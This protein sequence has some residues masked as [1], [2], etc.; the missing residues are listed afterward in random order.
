MH[1]NS[2]SYTDLNAM[3]QLKVGSKADSAENLQQVA[4]QFE[5]L[6]LNVMV[7]S[8]RDANQAFAEGNPLN[9]PQTRFYQD[10]YDS[11]LSVHLAEKQGMGLADVM[12]RQLSP[13][14]AAPAAPVSN[15]ATD[16]HAERPDHSA[17]LARRR[18]GVRAGWGEVTLGQVTAAAD[19]P[20]RTT[21]PASPAALAEPSSNWL[22][23][24]A[25]HAAA[26]SPAVAAATNAKTRFDS[27]A[28]FTRAM[29][30]M[31]EK[32]AARLG[33]DPHYLVAQAALETG[34]GKSI[35][36]NG[37]GTSSYNLFGI[38]SHGQWQGDSASVMTSEYRDGVR[39]QERASFRSYDSFEQSFDDYVDFLH[40]NGRYAQALKRTESGD[41]FF[42]E[43]QA[44]G[45][46]TDPR[47]ASKVSQI[48][49]KLI[50]ENATASVNPA[51]SQGRV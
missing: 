28:E 9:T 7:K 23:L 36:R 11:Q 19:K 26:P 29:L 16:A 51:T 15:T 8:M 43:L 10:M 30:P 44:A 42:R 18:L 49:R 40:R 45:Y 46:A 41:V 17:L 20:T 13:E 31:A 38:K 5:S 47:Y 3:A 48:A 2:I 14:Q 32:A 21:E 27:P 34:W 24:R 50:N 4:S 6:F 25:R 37:D 35:I 39:Q 33:V 12:L 22:P 1:S